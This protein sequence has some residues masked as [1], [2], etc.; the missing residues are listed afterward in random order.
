MD[1]GRSAPLRERLPARQELLPLAQVVQML[2]CSGAVVCL[3]LLAQ[4]GR[5]R[6]TWSSAAWAWLT[7][8]AAAQPFT[9]M[10]GPVGVMLAVLQFSARLRASLSHACGCVVAA[11]LRLLMKMLRVSWRKAKRARSKSRRA[12]KAQPS[13]AVAAATRRRRW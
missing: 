5:R 3:S 12:T 9:V 6:A 13:G 11:D 1:W 10:S 7:W 2:V 8:A 4:L